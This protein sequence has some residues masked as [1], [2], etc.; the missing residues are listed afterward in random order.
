M[1][2]IPR[3]ELEK[4]LHKLRP[5]FLTKET[6]IGDRSIA[7]LMTAAQTLSR[8]NEDEL[9]IF[10]EIQNLIEDWSRY[11]YHT[12]ASF[13]NYL[14]ERGNIVLLSNENYY[15]FE[16]NRIVQDG[17]CIKIDITHENL[18]ELYQFFVKD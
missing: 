7:V 11:T 3:E 4:N 6:I 12:G 2:Q 1:L 16:K 10:Q 13:T 18:A 17:S 8:E 9:F 14:R 5:C 15:F